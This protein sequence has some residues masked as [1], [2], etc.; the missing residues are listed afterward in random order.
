MGIFVHLYYY[1]KLLKLKEQPFRDYQ[2]YYIINNDWLNKFKTSN[3]YD[4][5]FNVLKKYDEKNSKDNI[6]DYYQLRNYQYTIFNDLS[7]FLTVEISDNFNINIDELSKVNEYYNDGFI[8]HC[9]I[10]E[11]ISGQETPKSDNLTTKYIKLYGNY[12]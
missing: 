8:I 12:I 5:I 6:I 4:K 3:N 10:I 2:D 1:E 11:L 7:N 9:K